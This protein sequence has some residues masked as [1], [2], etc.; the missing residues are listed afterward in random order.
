MQQN[1]KAIDTVADDKQ[2]GG[3]Y[4]V[5]RAGDAHSS[6]VSPLRLGVLDLES[7]SIFFLNPIRYQRKVKSFFKF[8]KNLIKAHQGL[9]QKK[10]VQ[11]YLRS[12]FTKYTT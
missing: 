4:G 6:F 3:F 11:L 10:Q 8:N 5:F 12:E 7:F 1:G 2:S 9:I